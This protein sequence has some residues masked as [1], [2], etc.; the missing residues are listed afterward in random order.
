MKLEKEQ[1]TKDG[2]QLPEAE[3]PSCHYKADAATS[4]SGEARPK[5]GD[6]TL[7]INCG[8]LAKFGQDYKLEPVKL[9]DLMDLTPRQHRDIELAQKFIRNHP[10]S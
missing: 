6:I 7:C 5:P 2:R 3:C 10:R 1:T 9:A 4:L 8:E